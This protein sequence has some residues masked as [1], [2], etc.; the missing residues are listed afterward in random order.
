MRQNLRCR[1]Y[2]SCLCAFVLCLLPLHGP[3]LCCRGPHC[4]MF[5]PSPL[6]DGL[7]FSSVLGDANRQISEY[8]FKLSKA[9]Q[10]ITTLEQ[11]VSPS[12][13]WYQVIYVPF[14]THLLP[15]AQWLTPWMPRF[16]ELPL[17]LDLYKSSKVE[18]PAEN[19][20]QGISAF[21][22]NEWDWSYNSVSCS[23]FKSL[24]EDCGL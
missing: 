20:W 16:F 11:S 23:Y 22:M 13:V 18:R 14:T 8:K 3:L 21:S 24:Q 9:E 5:T 12:C 10:D 1:R 7:L 6:W 19:T 2:R 17:Q 15:A 4:L